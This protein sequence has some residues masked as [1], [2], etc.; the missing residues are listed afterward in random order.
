MKTLLAAL[1]LAAPAVSGASA[2]YECDVT[3]EVVAKSD[4]AFYPRKPGSRFGIQFEDIATVVTIKVLTSKETD[5]RYAGYCDNVKNET[6]TL[7]FDAV[8]AMGYVVG[9]TVNFRYAYSSA[10]SRDKNYRITWTPR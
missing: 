7:V 8:E 9:T 6:A 5:P 2:I 10:R 3:A 4:D 1:L